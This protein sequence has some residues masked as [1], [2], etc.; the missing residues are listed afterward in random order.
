M[1]KILRL[2][3]REYK[4]SVK[5]KGFIIGLILAPI[6]MGGGLIVFALLKDRVDTTDKTMAVIDR[7]GMVAQVLVEAAENRR[8]T[9]V[10]DEKTGKK[11]KPEY[12]FEI[13]EPDEEDPEAQR[14]KLSDRV[15]NG[16]LHAFIEIG[17]D[18]VHP[19]E[20]RATVRIAYHAKNAAMDDLRGW[21]NWP[22]NNYLR[23]LRLADAGIDESSVKDL[24]HW[25]DVDAL[26]LVSVDKETGEVKG[27]ERANKVEAIL[28][29]I[30]LMMLMF[31]MVMMGVPGLLQSV[32]EEK[33]QRIAEVLLGSI[34]PFE[35]MMGKVLSGVAIALTSSAVYFIGGI[36]VVRHMGYERY[37]PYHMLPWFFAYM[38]MAIIMF[39]AMAAALGSTCSEAKDAQSLTFPMMLPM[40][41]PMFVYFPVVKEPMSSFATWMSLIPPFTPTLMLLRQTTPAGIPFWQPCVGML[42][43]LLF[44]VLFVWA[45]GRIFRVAILMQGTPPKLKNII[46]W[47]IRG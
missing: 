25:M 30:A 11:V 33:T 4:A 21:L 42:G 44:T 26:G 1:R 3:R 5:T 36:L 35:F 45:G 2:I 10:Y 12:I 6:F 41:I 19:K 37:I 7:S 13:V 43:V 40:L 38:L 39:G 17:P 9:E 23:K 29:P 34:K 27:A 15:R 14:L 18:V 32:M 16:E 20:D 46:R 24:F 31:L 22:I 28:I 47:A 8:K